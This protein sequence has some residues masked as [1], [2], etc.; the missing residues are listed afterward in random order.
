VLQDNWED[1]IRFP[2]ASTLPDPY[3][4]SVHFTRS[5]QQ[6][7]SKFVAIEDTGELRRDAVV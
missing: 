2:A 1:A 3:F 4:G 6:S 5:S 7:W